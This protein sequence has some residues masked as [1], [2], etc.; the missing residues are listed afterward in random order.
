MGCLLRLLLTLALMGGLAVAADGWVARQAERR[1]GEVAAATL[2][3]PTSVELPG[4]PFVLHVLR[5]RLPTA[6]LHARQ[7]PVPGTG[8]VVSR[9][10]LELHGVRLSP[11]ALLGGGQA[12]G[13]LPEADS[14]TF[15][16]V[17]DEQA[18]RTWLG[19]PDALDLRLA[20]GEVRLNVAGQI[21][22]VTPE[23]RDG[24][25]VLAELPGLPQLR[26]DL[27]G[28]PGGPWVERVDVRLGAIEISGTLRDV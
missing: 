7:V 12:A 3:A 8:A 5:G 18:L 19:V 10:E 17:L 6:L 26:A 22:A 27:H 15:L 14:G 28:L 9:L 1:A 13:R 4:R 23:A 21:V 24:G 20:G 11:S 25:V 2:G 16:A